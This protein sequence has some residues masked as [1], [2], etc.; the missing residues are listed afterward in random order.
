MK[1]TV[2][3]LA[4]I[5]LSGCENEVWDSKNE[6]TPQYKAF[7]MQ[8]KNRQILKE[9]RRQVI[10]PKAFPGDTVK[11][12]CRWTGK[13]REGVVTKTDI[14][15][16]FDRNGKYDQYADYVIIDSLTYDKRYRDDKHILSIENK[17]IK[18]E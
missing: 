5:T 2:I 13:T 6:E 16:R 3:M 18:G 10:T 15:L 8:T 17:I 9:Q 4:V 14:R 1:W 12:V 11:Y 7:N